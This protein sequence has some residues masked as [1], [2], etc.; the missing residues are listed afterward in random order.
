MLIYAGT[1]NWVGALSFAAIALLIGTLLHYSSFNLAR[2]V[3]KFFREVEQPTSKHPRI[4]RLL[5][6]TFIRR[7]FGEN[8]APIP[9][10]HALLKQAEGKIR[11]NIE[12]AYPNLEGK[13]FDPID[14]L[15]QGER[16]VFTACKRSILARSSELGRTLKEKES[17]INLIGSLPLPLFFFSFGLLL[18][19]KDVSELPLR[20]KGNT[21]VWGVGIF[22]FAVGA[23]THLLLRFHALRKE[24]VRVCVETF[25]LIE[26]GLAESPKDNQPE[27][28]NEE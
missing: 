7:F 5:N 19:V 26:H 3:H 2:Q 27:A 20:A 23:I 6:Y 12:S 24:E 4:R 10:R 16:E 9:Y 11:G 15:Y 8:L 14:Q 17:E 18:H 28:I 22:V 1:T 21:W 13:Y 25:F